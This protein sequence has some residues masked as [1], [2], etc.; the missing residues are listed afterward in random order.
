MKFHRMPFFLTKL[1]GPPPVKGKD[2]TAESLMAAFRFVMQ[3]KTKKLAKALGEIMSAEKGI[4]TGGSIFHAHLPLEF[5]KFVFLSDPFIISFFSLTPFEGAKLMRP[6]QLL[7]IALIATCVCVRKF[8]MPSMGMI[9][10]IGG[11]DIPVATGTRR[12]FLPGVHHIVAGVAGGVIESLMVRFLVL[13]TFL[14]FYVFFGAHTKTQ[15]IPSLFQEPWRGFWESGMPGLVRGIWRGIKG[16]FVYPYRGIIIF[17][18]EIESGMFTPSWHHDTETNHGRYILLGSEMDD[19]TL[20][21]GKWME[22]SQ[23]FETMEDM[24]KEGALIG[25]QLPGFSE[26]PFIPYERF[27]FKARIEEIKKKVAL[28]RRSKQRR[29]ESAPEEKEEREINVPVALCLTLLGFIL[30]SLAYSLVLQMTLS[31]QPMNFE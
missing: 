12:F 10:N 29:W 22:L 30:V 28:I 16:V 26:N 27:I 23:Y 4:E 8:I 14:F 21:K 18:R 5:I 13:A 1:P 2:L 6:N 3:P 17:V 31:H 7:S 25:E 9:Q 19:T 20:F 24:A 15:L 11:F